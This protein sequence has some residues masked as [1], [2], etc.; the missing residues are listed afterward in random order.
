MKPNMATEMPSQFGNT[1]VVRLSNGVAPQAVGNLEPALKTGVRILDLMS[2][3]PGDTIACEIRMLTEND[4]GYETL[5]YVWGDA[6]ETKPIKV[7]GKTRE[8][9]INLFNALSRLRLLNCT[10]SIVG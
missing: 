9:T 10:K 5:S 3:K 4:K 7:A 1:Q 2:G 6:K 8:V